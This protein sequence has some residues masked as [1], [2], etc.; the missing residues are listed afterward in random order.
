MQSSSAPDHKVQDGL[1][2]PG[3]APPATTLLVKVVVV[4]E[5]V[6]PSCTWRPPLSA[7][8]RPPVY[9]FPLTTTVLLPACVPRAVPG[10]HATC[11]AAG[12]ERLPACRLSTVGLRGRRRLTMKVPPPETPELREKLEAVT[13]AD[14]PPVMSS[15]PPAPVP[16]SCTELPV[17]L[18]PA[19]SAAALAPCSGLRLL[20]HGLLHDNS[21][22]ERLWDSKSGPYRRCATQR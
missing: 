4:T 8:P 14:W 18:H 13:V 20:C 5:R 16:M 21:P 10:G 19:E 3:R 7:V 15:P 9:E 6:V 12:T 2:E 1:L 17:T 11:A 22:G